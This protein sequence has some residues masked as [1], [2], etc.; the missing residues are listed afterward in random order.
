MDFGSVNLLNRPGEFTWPI[1]AMTYVYV[2][3][4]LSHIED[5]QEQTL[6]KAFLAAL[7]DPA[8]INVCAEEFAFT[9]VPDNVRQI[10][11]AGI[12]MIATNTSAIPWTFESETVPG[13]GQGDYVISEK[14]RS[15]GEYQ[16]N[17]FARDSTHFQDEITNVRAELATEQEKVKNLEEELSVIRTQMGG[18]AN[19]PI[20]GSSMQ[21]AD[22]TEDEAGQI[23]AALIMSSISIVFWAI[24]A[25]VVA[26]RAFNH[27]NKDIPEV[28]NGGSGHGV[29]KGGSG[30]GAAARTAA[31]HSAVTQESDMVA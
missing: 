5:P 22:F 9:I 13:E 19:T 24:A 20:V 29:I 7:Y 31:K 15:Y 30:H 10:G 11:L 3:K 12:D 14:R 16:R 4:D 18:D 8:Y 25:A 2:R 28:M 23:S 1:V 27:P 26:F 17:E 6:L 21:Y